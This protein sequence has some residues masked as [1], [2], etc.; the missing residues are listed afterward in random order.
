ML[1]LCGGTLIYAGRMPSLKGTSAAD[2]TRWGVRH[3][4]VFPGP[5]GVD[6]FIDFC[7]FLSK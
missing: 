7:M 4:V 1:N 5:H 2:A 6:I 3:G